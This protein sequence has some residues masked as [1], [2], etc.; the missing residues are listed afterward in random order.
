MV[1]PATGLQTERRH[2]PLLPAAAARHQPLPAA[3]LGP[4]PLPDPPQE[5]EEEGVGA[6]GWRG[7]LGG[8][9]LCS[10]RGR[11]PAGG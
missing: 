2:A 1:T 9:C 4:E 6:Q 10:V 8:G 7:A 5:G 11:R 3:A